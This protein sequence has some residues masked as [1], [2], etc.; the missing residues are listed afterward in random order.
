MRGLYVHIPFCLQKCHYCDF[1]ITVDRSPAVKERFFQAL[2]REVEQAAERHGRFSFDTLYFG[3]GTPSALE[4]EEMERI[5]QRLRKTFSFA[6]EA[7][8]TCEVNPGDVDRRKLETYRRLRINRISVGAQSFTDRLL[9]EMNRPHGAR[10]IEETVRALRELGFE[11]V[12]LDLILRLPGQALDNARDSVRQAVDLGVS[13]IVLYDLDVHE[14]TVYG[15]RLKQGTL[16]LPDEAAHERMFSGAETILENAG[17]LHYEVANFAKPGF[18]SK[19]NL[20]YWTNQEYLGL[21]PGAFSYLNG[22]R[23]QFAPDVGRYLAKSETSDW[24]P[25][26]SEKISD[27]NREIETLLTGLRLSRGLELDQFSRIR[28]P[29]EKTLEE[30]IPQGL[31]ERT[32]NRVALTRRGRYVAESVIGRIVQS[33]L[34]D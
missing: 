28:E 1:V 17:Y 29:L 10:A 34:S 20:L 33:C 21:G 11:N 2:E 22:V 26:E 13:Q 32:G 3:G 18:E 19:H 14:K 9:Q 27:Q 23:S 16:A 30:L 25:D 31:V 6:P 15:R 5:V 7:E 4:P 24:T 8:T 12:S